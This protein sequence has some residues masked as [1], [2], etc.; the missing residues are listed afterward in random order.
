MAAHIF[1][2][3]FGT[4]LTLRLSGC[5]EPRASDEYISWYATN[6]ALNTTARTLPTSVISCLANT[7]ISSSDTTHVPVEGQRW[8]RGGPQGYQFEGRA[9][10]NKLFF[11]NLFEHNIFGANTNGNALWLTPDNVFVD[12][13]VTNAS[14]HVWIRWM[15]ADYSY[16]LNRL[17]TSPQLQLNFML[18]GTT[19]SLPAPIGGMPLMTS[20]TR[21]GRPMFLIPVFLDQ[22]ISPGNVARFRDKLLTNGTSGVKNV[23]WANE[24]GA[25]TLNDLL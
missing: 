1:K 7:N 17:R 2:D 4:G 12:S 11:E 16:L 15:P 5:V 22:W 18:I 13:Q 21:T 20:V 14:Y 25:L 10:K 6:R 23:P 19:N 9:V 24:V 8:I 3:L